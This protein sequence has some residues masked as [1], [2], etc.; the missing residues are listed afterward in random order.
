MISYAE[1]D[2]PEPMAT[3]LI[4]NIFQKKSAEWI[5]AFRFHFFSLSYKV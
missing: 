5:T 4:L 2:L 1:D 3:V